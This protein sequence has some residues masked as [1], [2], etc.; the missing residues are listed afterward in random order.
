MPPELSEIDLGSSGPQGLVTFIIIAGFTLLVALIAGLVLRRWVRSFVRRTETSLD[1]LA[2]DVLGK[3]VVIAILVAGLQV[4]LRTSGILILVS[5]QLLGTA[6]FFA[7]WLL[8]FVTLSR[9]LNVVEKWCVSD[10]QPRV[11]L[12]VRE[13]CP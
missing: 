11:A 4:A 1:D 9:L 13:G 10:I 8:F 5:P 3:P 2:L 7:Y 6:F 12:L